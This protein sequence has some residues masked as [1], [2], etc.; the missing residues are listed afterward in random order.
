MERLFAAALRL[1]PHRFRSVY[2]TDMQRHFVDRYSEACRT[3]RRAGF[4][5]STFANVCATA[6]AEH[7]R[8][9]LEPR[10]TASA[11]AAPAPEGGHVSS[12]IQDVRYAG[13][14]LIRQPGF[15]LF[16]ILTLAI[17]IGANTAVFSVVNGVLL[18]PLPFPD[19]DRLVSVISRFDPESGF[20]FPEFPL[21]PPEFVDYRAESRALEDVAAYA[22][23]SITVGGAEPERVVGA[24]ASANL[25]SVLRVQPIAGRGFLASDDRPD[26]PPT[27]VLAY[28][29][30]QSRFGGDRTV[31]GRNIPMNGVPTTVIGVMPEGFA[32]PGTTTRIWVPLGIDPN[33][34][35]SRKSHFIRAIGR[36]ADSV[37]I[38]QAGVEMRTLMDGWKARFPDIHTGH[39]LFLRPLLDDVA[40]QVR[41]AL[42]LLLGATGFVLLIVCANVANVVLARGEARTREMAIRGALGARRGRLVRLSLIESALLGALGGALGVGLAYAGVRA[43]IALDPTSIP[44][45]GEVALDGR[46]LLFAAGVSVCAVA[47]FGLVPALRGACVDLQSTLRDSSHST[48]GSGARLW[49]RR[50]LVTLEV[51]LAVVLVVGAGLMIRSIDRLFTVNPGFNADGL[52]MSAV[53]LPAADYR[54]PDRIVGFYDALLERVR[55]LPGVTAAAVTSGV[56]LWSDTGVW[57]FEVEGRPVPAPGEMAWNAGVTIVSPG[58]FETLGM[59]LVRGRFFA[60]PDDARAMTVTAINET[61]A[62]RFFPGEDPIG[63]RIRVSGNTT[64]AAWMTI[65]G[66]VGD[67]RDRTLDEAPRPIYY[68]LESQMAAT[69]NGPARSLALV[70]R[71]A[72]APDAAI[73][74]IRSIVRGLDP[75]LPVFDVQTLDTIVAGSLARPRFMTALLSLFATI[76]LLLGASGIYGVLSYTVSRRT[77]ELGIRRALGAPPSRLMG[78]VVRQ[79]MQPVLLGLIAGLAASFWTTGLL[80]SQLFGVSPTDTATYAAVAAGVVSIALAACILPAR[81][82]LGVS[83]IVALRS[84]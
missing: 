35:G 81:R 5:V 22:R 21:S 82:A 16:V 74:A 9:S 32:Y 78:D 52:T 18:K 60:D 46:M 37:S 38:E 14:L 67:I 53:S 66:V 29:Y 57:D 49:L 43:M 30:W 77:Q 40:G 2:A 71:V 42:L 19:S 13:R 34:P 75:A 56:P 61:M 6:A 11:P 7:W 72:G 84:E 45:A 58:F 62:A 25:F 44:R 28:G 76:G 31:L 73:Q 12:L 23:R 10:A 8:S 36:L 54:E 64:P 59:R 3:G 15:S 80:E 63:R 47:M 48:S 65:V 70:T 33:S 39:Y 79:G 26:A 68:L 50:G 27:A 20:N 51:A 83:P 69:T 41:T 17:G 1:Y 4:L 24:A 55:A